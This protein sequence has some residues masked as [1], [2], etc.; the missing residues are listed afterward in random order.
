[1]VH[2]VSRG[3][4]VTTTESDTKTTRGRIRVEPGTKRVRAYL[5]GE[6]VADTTRPALVWE[7]PAYYFPAADVRTELL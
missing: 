7:V 4:Q 5:G 2:N 1:M 6:V 3:P